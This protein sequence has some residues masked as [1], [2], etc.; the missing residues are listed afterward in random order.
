MTIKTLEQWRQN[1]QLA[2][3][4]HKV[5]N[6]AEWQMLMKIMERSEHVRHFDQNCEPIQKLGRIEGW[7]LY[8]KRLNEAAVPLTIEQ[9]PEPTF[10]DPEVPELEKKG[11]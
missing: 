3:W 6:S 11:K 9:L 4:A 10:E 7:D 8:D 2:E 5:M 1:P